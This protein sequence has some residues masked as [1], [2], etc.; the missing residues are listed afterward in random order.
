[1]V[2]WH[3]RVSKIFNWFNAVGFSSQ[4]YPEI[5][6]LRKLLNQTTNRPPL[7][8]L[9]QGCW[10]E[11]LLLEVPRSEIRASGQNFF[12]F[13][14]IFIFSSIYLFYKPFILY[15]KIEKFKMLFVELN[16]RLQK[17]NG[18]DRILAP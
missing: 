2:D 4:K 13:N 11:E 17:I 18:E 5:D 9:V 14:F 8:N 6:L 12:F 1:M 15:Y 7:I 16:I 10:R 3:G